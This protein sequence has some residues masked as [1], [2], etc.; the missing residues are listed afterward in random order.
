[1]YVFILSLFRIGEDNQV[2]CGKY[3]GRHIIQ[4]AWRIVHP[5]FP[6]RGECASGGSTLNPS[7]LKNN[8]R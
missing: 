6:R 3:C 4:S 2:P 7:P 5:L 1:M 8:L